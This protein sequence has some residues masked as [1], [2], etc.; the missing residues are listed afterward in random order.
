M[1]IFAQSLYEFVIEYSPLLKTKLLDVFKINNSESH[2]LAIDLYWELLKMESIDR[3]LCNSSLTCSIC[4]SIDSSFN[5]FVQEILNAPE[6]S[7]DPVMRSL[8][9]TLIDDVWFPI[10]P[11]AFNNQVV[12][13]GLWKSFFCVLKN[14]EI[15]LKTEFLRDA[16]SLFIDKEANA[17]SLIAQRGWISWILCMIPSVQGNEGKILLRKEESNFVL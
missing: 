4:M 15:N 5:S 9:G 1:K 2:A 3:H 12:R 13:P 7:T 8:M 17:F 16:Y 10:K 11:I 6:F 14:C